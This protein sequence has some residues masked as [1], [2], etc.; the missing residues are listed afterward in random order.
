MTPTEKS[1]TTSLWW[2]PLREST[3]WC[4]DRN[5][6]STCW[7]DRQGMN[8]RMTPIARPHGCVGEAGMWADV[9]RVIFRKNTLGNDP[10]WRYGSLLQERGH[11]ILLACMMG[12]RPLLVES[13]HWMWHRH[14]RIEQCEP[15]SAY[16]RI[17]R[18]WKAAF[19]T[20]LVVSRRVAVTCKPK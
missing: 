1:N 17:I 16:C 7:C 15:E 18:E 4:A 2:L 12:G 19:S 10:T 14:A 13:S 8:N 9:F 6:D 11:T 20:F 5:Q 3:C